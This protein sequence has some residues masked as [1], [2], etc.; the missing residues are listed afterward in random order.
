MHCLIT[1]FIS[2]HTFRFFVCL[3][4]CLFSNSFSSFVDYSEQNSTLDRYSVTEKSHHLLAK[5]IYIQL[6]KMYSKLIYHWVPPQIL[7][8]I[9]LHEGRVPSISICFFW[10]TAVH[11]SAGLFFYFFSASC[12][13][14]FHVIIIH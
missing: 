2:Y 1:I 10:V 3:F 4:V 14:E 6:L 12:K 5:I 8:I 9:I 13:L 11:I 7:F